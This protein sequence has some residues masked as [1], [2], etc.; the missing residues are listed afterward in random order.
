[1]YVPVLARQTWALVSKFLAIKPT[2]QVKVAKA[3][4][5]DEDIDAKAEKARRKLEYDHRAFG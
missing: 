2:F 5:V 4:T 1:M 3:E